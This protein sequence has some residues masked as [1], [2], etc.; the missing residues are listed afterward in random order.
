M[1][2]RIEMYHRLY[3]LC[4]VGMLPG[5]LLSIFLYI[6][7]NM[8]EVFGYFRRKCVAGRKTTGKSKL[9][10]SFLLIAVT[11][12]TLWIGLGLL[13]HG[14]EEPADAE[15]SKVK[16]TC[17]EANFQIDEKSYYR[18]SFWVRIE[19][20]KEKT[21][22]DIQS[23]CE[24]KLYK[25]GEEVEAPD[26]EWSEEEDHM[27]GELW[28]KA[29]QETHMADGVYELEVIWTEKEELETPDITDLEEPEDNQNSMKADA[30]EET[31]IQE[32]KDVDDIEEIEREIELHSPE[33]VLD[34][35]APEIE[36]HFTTP[37]G[38]PVSYGN[39]QEYGY[40]FSKEPVTAKTQITD[41]FSGIGQ[42]EVVILDADGEVIRTEKFEREPE[43]SDGEEDES[44]EG[45]ADDQTSYWEQSIGLPENGT[46][47]N[48]T[49][50]I[51]VEDRLENTDSQNGSIIVESEQAHQTQTPI[52]ME[53]L[54]EPGRMVDGEAY[55]RSDVR[56]KYVFTDE[57][58]G[59]R[60]LSI[61][62]GN[63]LTEEK[64][65]LEQ[66]GTDRTESPGQPIT[67]TFEWEGTIAAE[68][69]NQNDVSVSATVVDN[70]GYEDQIDEKLH[71]DTTVP[72]ITVEYDKN[73]PIN[74]RFYQEPRTATVSIKERNFAVEDV[75]FLITGTDGV[76]PAIGEWTSFGEGDE[77]VHRCQVTFSEDGE[78][79]FSVKFQ[80]KAGNQAVYDRVDEFV[81]DQ[82][83]PVLT[84]QWDTEQSQNGNY[85][86]NGRQALIQ[87]EERNFAPEEM[88]VLVEQEYGQSQSSDW[89]TQGLIHQKR[90]SFSEDGTYGLTVR[91]RDLAGNVCAEYR[92]DSFV[93]DQTP[94]ELEIR[95]VRDGS[96][97][98]GVLKPEI[99]S[100]DL[101]Y[102]PGSLE[103]RL[104]GSLR[105][106]RT[107]S[108]KYVMASDGQQYTYENFPE[109]PSTDDI[110]VLEAVARD[111]AGNES[112]R[113]CSFSVNRFGS[114]YTFDQLT[115]Q[116]LDGNRYLKNGAQMTITE[117]NVDGL[118]LQNILCSHNG[119]SRTLE[120][121]RDYTV[122]EKET[123]GDWKQYVYQI[124]KEV[125]SQNGLYEIAVC[126][127]DL[128]S[129]YSNTILKDRTIRFTVDHTPPRIRVSGIRNQGIYREQERVINL[130][131]EDNLHLE[132]AEVTYDGDTTSYDA[133]TL[134]ASDRGIALRLG[135]SEQW[136]N[137]RIRAID[138]AGNE[139]EENLNFLIW[140]EKNSGRNWLWLFGILLAACVIIACKTS[141][142]PLYCMYRK[143]VDKDGRNDR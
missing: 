94:P 134:R 42:A 20:E 11:I 68:H 76:R 39:Y 92:S 88:E 6:R 60:T 111:L 48:G 40:W 61:K 50:L 52:Q 115:E 17:Q 1:E 102:Q 5:L 16:I 22:E 29:D 72:E 90:I 47:F 57:I 35:S 36:M 37:S 93:I 69:N 79:T 25:D 12:F 70:A 32:N 81:I 15:G 109:E 132:Q 4:M 63:E 85:Y 45:T 95:G 141:R 91:G 43:N 9:K 49:I 78:Y 101:N 58:S 120:K 3:V 131:L 96:A 133:E 116:L 138:A 129:N 121:N 59:L 106:A 30:I 26:M 77:T 51:N 2:N 41:P 27:Q 19:I 137:L 135:K 44:E 118:Y 55:Y 140:P 67:H 83:A 97:N 84:V 117:T 74:E 21:M 33:L 105:G 114:V 62:A 54:T 136:Q 110:Y 23:S 126:S 112:R 8:Y 113:I 127:E 10:V 65:Y 100:Q 130:Y 143:A 66:A 142:K 119:K 34:T 46:E 104:T 13:A 98:A 75:E 64:N 71:I 128:A 89:E 7:L 14:E 123:L 125:F 108:G 24:W 56:V 82:T 87:V 124:R 86:A 28:I 139:T 18:D 38:D 99:I 107:F 103:V 31:N 53:I 80:D 122:S 73:D